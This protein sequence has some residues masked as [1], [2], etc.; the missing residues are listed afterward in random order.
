[1]FST[2]HILTFTDTSKIK[3]PKFLIG[4]FITS[5]QENIKEQPAQLYL[6]ILF[7]HLIAQD[8]ELLDA[9]VPVNWNRSHIPIIIN[10]TL[11]HKQIPKII[12]FYTSPLCFGILDIG[13]MFFCGI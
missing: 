9:L 4:L 7:W 3:T 11:F 6:F 13:T 10:L 5:S 12:H 8:K 2:N 1:M